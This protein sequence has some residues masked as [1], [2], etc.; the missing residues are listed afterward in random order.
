MAAPQCRH[1]R[2]ADLG[3]DLVRLEFGEGPHPDRAAHPVDEDIDPAKPIDGGGEGG[4][5]AVISFQIAYMACRFSGCAIGDLGHEARP[6]D[7]QHLAPFSRG[8]LR[9]H[10][11]DTLGSTGDD[12]HL[13]RK[14]IREDHAVTSS[15]GANFS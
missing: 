15:V 12:Q 9:H 13:A 10:A 3:L 7:E 11:P 5:C 14:T 1:Q 6:V 8:A 4:C 2:T